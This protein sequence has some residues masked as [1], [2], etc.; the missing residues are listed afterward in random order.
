MVAMFKGHL[1]LIFRLQISTTDSKESLE[2][3]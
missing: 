3:S 2:I 1:F